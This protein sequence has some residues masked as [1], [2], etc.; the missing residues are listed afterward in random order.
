MLPKIM[1]HKT[2]K[3]KNNNNIIEEK[4]NDVINENTGT[5]YE[6]N[7]DVIYE[8]NNIVIDENNINK[9]IN[10]FKKIKSLTVDIFDFK[11]FHIIF[12]L[13]HKFYNGTELYLRTAI[14]IDYLFNY[15]LTEKDIKKCINELINY[16]KK[17]MD[18]FTDVFEIRYIL[19]KWYN[20][21][22][23]NLIQDID[24]IL[25]KYKTY[26][27]ELFNRLYIKYVIKPHTNKIYF[28]KKL[29]F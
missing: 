9:M 8:N 23:K 6:N 5:I 16:N 24:K 14:L 1:P 27:S 25:D 28:K 17:R 22:N 4:N 11:T 18:N 7:N 10:S 15:N 20:H 13:L 3:E 29:W 21:Y 19:H 2:T 12:I 26:E